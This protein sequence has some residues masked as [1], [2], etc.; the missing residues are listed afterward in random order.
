MNPLSVWPSEEMPKSP[1]ALEIDQLVFFIRTSD[2]PHA[3]HS[4][5][6]FLTRGDRVSRE[7]LAA[8]EHLVF[9]YL[10]AA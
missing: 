1:R 8:Y 3:R 9:M 4:L 5:E 2:L 6:N 10:A 7:I